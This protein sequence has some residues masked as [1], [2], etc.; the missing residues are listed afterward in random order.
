MFVKNCTAEQTTEL[1]M[2]GSSTDDIITEEKKKKKKEMK[3]V[4]VP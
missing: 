1:S 2:P 4:H 3:N